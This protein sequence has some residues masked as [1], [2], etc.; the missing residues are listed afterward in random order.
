MRFKVDYERSG[1]T[2]VILHLSGE[3]DLSVQEH[4]LA[5]IE[6]ALVGPPAAV[7]VD[8]AGLRFLDCAGVRAL[9]Q[10]QR[11]AQACGCALSVRNPQPMVEQ[12]LRIVR[13]ADVLGLPPAG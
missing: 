10:A 2:G 6:E 12:V 1:D 13:V 4:L 8:L 7:V 9:L 11:A 5:M 3:V